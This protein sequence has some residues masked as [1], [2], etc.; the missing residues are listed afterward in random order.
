[1]TLLRDIAHAAADPQVDLPS[2]LR[3]CKILAARLGSPEFSTWI[4]WELDGYPDEQST[5]DYR[6]LPAGFYGQFMN[7]AWRYDKMP[8]P[9]NV[10]PE[11]FHD[12][13][14]TNVFRGG[15]AQVTA[16]AKG[17]TILR[18]ELV[19]A[20]QGRIDGGMNCVSA[21]QEIPACEI[22]QLL[23][24][25]RNRILDFVLKIEDENPD[26]GEAA[27]DSHPVPTER[28]QNLVNNYFLGM[29]NIAQNSHSFNQT[30][31]TGIQPGDLDSLKSYLASEGIPAGALEELESA[32]TTDKKT[33]DGKGL[34]SRVQEWI[35]KAASGSWEITKGISIPLIVGAIKRY[36]HLG[37]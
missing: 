8:V 27:V 22:V 26:A 33:G 37:P 35:G 6:R 32:V 17:A 5:P 12:A 31:N 30:A 9:R 24:A 7:A 14:Y 13:L 1:M 25:V 19:F 10:I 16:L 11:E 3:K 28:L 4:A 18:P 21:W 34:G 36:Y 20:L 2:L 15:I 23:S 29:T